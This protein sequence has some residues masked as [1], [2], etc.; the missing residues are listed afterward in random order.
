MFGSPR[1]S[2]RLPSLRARK[3]IVRR[4]G[5]RLLLEELESR[6][7]LSATLPTDWVAQPQF[8]VTPL[9]GPSSSVVYTPAQI[10][11]AY[12]VDAIRFANGLVG[13]GSGQTIAI[14]DA[15]DDPNIAN[16][17]WGFDHTFGVADP[18]SFVKAMP[19]GQPAFDAGWA[20]EIALDVEWAHAI[21]PKASILLVEARSASIS[22][23]LGAIN[24]ARNQ[25][26]V[27]AISM[28]WGGGEFSTEKN[29]D[30]YFTT[31]AGHIGGF[32]IPGGITFVASS[33]DS[34]A[35]YGPEWPSVSPN[36]LAVGG[37][38]LRLT[39]TNTYASESGWSGSGGGVSRYEFQP[40]FQLGAQGSGYRT[41]PDVAYDADPSTGFYVYNTAGLKAGQSGWWAYGGTSA[42]APQWAALIALADQGRA[43]AGK[44]SL[45]NAQATLYGLPATDFH[46]VTV[47]NNGYPTLGGY[48]LVTGRGSPYA[49][50]VVRDLVAAGSVTTAA[51]Q[52]TT[53]TTKAPVGKAAA[54]QPGSD[55]TMIAADLAFALAS[56]PVLNS[57][58][59]FTQPTVPFLSDLGR[60]NPNA[61]SETGRGKSPVT[62]LAGEQSPIFGGHQETTS[63]LSSV[64]FDLDPSDQSNSDDAPISEG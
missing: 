52:T 27:V 15:Y 38:S 63:G 40:S 60:T 16:D 51:V 56:R 62:G 44:G 17:L 21:A 23:L 5:P 64:S 4:K 35:A 13:D 24:Y 61:S 12:G 47:G 41:T 9:A 54:G 37:T 57:P 59:F 53:T 33:G 58:T 42:G 46:D 8:D 36:V 25:P 43:Y 14:V 2:F 1:F 11:H 22:D 48:D 32:G 30:G 50:R 10:R 7:L 34:G 18:P 19:Q 49:D 26:G 29:Y 45:T 20:G 6:A 28:S 55:P 3:P 31:P 39:S